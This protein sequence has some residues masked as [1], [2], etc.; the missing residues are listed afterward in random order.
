MTRRALAGRCCTV[1][2]LAAAL[3]CA[4]GAAGA[5]VGRVYCNV[6]E[7]KATQLS[8]AVRIDLRCDGQLNA[9]IDL[10]DYV[11]VDAREGRVT[12]AKPVRRVVR[13][14]WRQPRDLTAVPRRRRV[15]HVVAGHL[16]ADLTRRQRRPPDVERR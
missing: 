1:A 6:T 12:A 9:E 7:V 16:Q 13:P 5:Q 11:E 2:L 15:R 10:L 8:N 3:V 4:C 14:Q